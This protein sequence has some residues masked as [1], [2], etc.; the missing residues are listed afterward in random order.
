MGEETPPLTQPDLK[1]W[2][3]L[4]RVKGRAVKQVDSSQSREKARV[5]GKGVRLPFLS[6]QETRREMRE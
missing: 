2:G 3:T 4:I 6:T 1:S 5:M